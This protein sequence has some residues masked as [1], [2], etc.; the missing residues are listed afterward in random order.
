MTNLF[1][2]AAFILCSALALGSIWMS[3]QTVATYN[4][5]F[6]KR[7]F[8]YLVSFYAFAFY[9]LWGPLGLRELMFLGGAGP[10]A[11]AGATRWLPLLAMPFAA[12]G[13]LVF[14]TIPHALGGSGRVPAA[15]S[16]YAGI[17]GLALPLAA[18]L[19]FPA[20][21]TPAGPLRVVAD[22]L[23]GVM[24][25]P[26]ALF[27]FWACT[28]IWGFSRKAGRPQE[29]ILK[30]F[31]GLTLLALPIRGGAL[32]LYH[33]QASLAAAGLVLYFLSAALPFLY[34]Y[35]FSDRL[36]QPVFAEAT[37]VENLR[38]LVDRYGISPREEEVIGKICEGKTNQQIA[39]ELFISL[40]TVK[41]HTHRIYTKIGINSRLKLVQL[42][43]G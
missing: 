32:L 28:C 31:G 4:S 5:L 27:T 19:F 1:F 37:N 8:Y 18:F 13:W 24:I 41:D 25:W 16:W 17:L 33:M 38:L 2:I 7:Y 43:N 11:T 20:W 36:F 14:G 9:A 10:E 26:D 30:V 23:T 3:R 12:I 6:H 29:S 21:P 35:R 34:V 39:D 40:Q 22:L 15:Y 42:L